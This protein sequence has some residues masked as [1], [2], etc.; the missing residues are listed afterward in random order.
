MK[1]L[2]IFIGLTMASIIIGL[3]FRILRNMI[4][5]MPWDHDFDVAVIGGVCGGIITSI[6]FIQKLRKA[7]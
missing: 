4:I 3:S 1:T 2:G 5:N 7:D 6:I